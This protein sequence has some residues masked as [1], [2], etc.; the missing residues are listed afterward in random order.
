MQQAQDVDLRRACPNTI[1]GDERC[2]R[3][4]QFPRAAP[5]ARAAEFREIGETVGGSLNAITLL[6]GCPNIVGGDMSKLRSTLSKCS[7]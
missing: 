4:H 6:D 3:D 7:R 1:D 5:A 2:P